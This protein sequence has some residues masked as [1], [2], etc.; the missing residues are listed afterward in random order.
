MI[1]PNEFSS[2]N[3]LSGGVDSTSPGSDYSS[4][5]VEMTSP[6]KSAS[7]TKN[8]LTIIMD[9]LLHS[10]TSG[11]CI[12]AFS[13]DVT[14]LKRGMALHGLDITSDLTTH[15]CQLLYIT[16]LVSGSCVIHSKQVPDYISSPDISSNLVKH[17][18]HPSI[19]KCSREDL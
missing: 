18:I 13:S 16:H 10:Y 1:S 2:G 8:G 5:D 7:V 14:V 11:D 17:E 3:E 12:S 6:N 9:T 15:E 19:T 4:R